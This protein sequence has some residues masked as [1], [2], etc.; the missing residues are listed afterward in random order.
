MA[1]GSL[2]RVRWYAREWIA[3]GLC[4]AAVGIATAIYFSR[5]V[6]RPYRLSISGGSAD[7][8]RHQIA[9]QLATQ[10][11]SH[12]LS[13]SLVATSGSRDALDLVDAHRLDVAFVQGGLDPSLHPRVRQV[14][15]LHVEPL[16]L[17]VRPALY[18]AISANLAALKGKTV[19]LGPPASGTH[20]LARDVLKFAGL[21]PN[22]DQGSVD[23]T[24]VTLSY[25]D[26]LKEQDA[27]RLPDAVFTVSAL[28][29]PVV[30]A[31]VM[32]QHYQLVSLPFGEAFALNALNRLS[33]QPTTEL[34]D[35][36]SDVSR[37]KIY[38]ALIPP[39]TY[40]VEP[41][42]PP[43][44]LA[45]FGPRLLLVANEQVPNRAVQQTL[46]T[47][48]APSFAQ[49]SK[50]PLE[51]SLLD[52]SPEYPVHP[53]TERF[54]E[55]NKPLVAGDVID[56]LEKGTSLAGA[57]LGAL[58]FLWQWVRQHFRRKRELGFESYMLQ[59]ASIEEQALKLEMDAT[60][61]IRE[62]LRLQRDLCRLKN[63]ALARFAEGKLE[64]GQLMSGFVSQVND[65]RNYLNRLIVHQRD[66]LEEQAVKERRTAESVWR[67]ALGGKAAEHSDPSTADESPVAIARPME[68]PQP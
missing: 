45:T 55:L 43:R 13:F 54:R 41:P 57:I 20:D 32:R 22:R 24:V 61:E 47:I 46:E 9:Q 17:L 62:L 12:G 42:T 21:D 8:L 66:N 51:S 65:A 60:L 30:R 67:E 31:L 53:G 59:V 14:A 58:F 63:T 26:L 18:G 23:Y 4:L 38:P 44:E 39:F 3:A 40:G 28:P 48:F 29:S 6:R 1:T 35:A 68:S 64:G 25:G 37:V 11:A 19:N 34:Q 52:V 2:K 5:S 50:P 10:G 15:A 49:F 36:K 33:A 27:A 16:H 56:L 7:G